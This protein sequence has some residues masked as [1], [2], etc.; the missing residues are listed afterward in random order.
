MVDALTLIKQKIVITV[1]INNLLQ[2]NFATIDVVEDGLTDNMKYSIDMVSFLKEQVTIPYDCQ[3][4][5]DSITSEKTAMFCL[6]HMCNGDLDKL[7]DYVA[8][9]VTPRN[10]S[11]TYDEEMVQAIVDRIHLKFK[12]Y[13]D[14]MEAFNRSKLL[15]EFKDYYNDLRE[16]TTDDFRK[17]MDAYVPPSFVDAQFGTRLT[18]IK[19]IDDYL[20]SYTRISSSSQDRTGMITMEQYDGF[21]T[22]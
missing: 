15:F 2:L 18:E 17:L 20:T 5:F 19:K 3:E 7:R 13:G 16:K 14:L 21:R 11:A 4:Y 6:R 8:K 22:T 9:H 12:T 10:G 1:S